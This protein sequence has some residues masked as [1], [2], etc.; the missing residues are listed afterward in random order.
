MD[1]TE[2]LRQAAEKNKSIVCMGLDPVLE[3]IPVKG[4]TE[5]RITKFY[6]DILNAVNSSD[7]KPGI[8]K[9]NY[10]FYAQYGFE[11]LRALKK[12]IEEYKKHFLV[13]LDCKRADIG[14]TSAAYAKEVFDFW[15]ADAI[16]VQPYLGY[17]SIKPFIDYCKKGK[18]V[19]LLVRTSNPGAREVQDL[20]SGNK[21][22]YMKI[23]E[24]VLKYHEPGVSAVVGAT[25]PQELEKISEFFVKS[26][27]SVPF[28]IPGVG[29]Q[30]GSAKEVVSALKKTK[31][32]LAIHRI[33]SSSGINYAYEK[34]NTKDYADAAV[35]AI[36]EL[37]GE[38]GF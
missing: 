32:E 3:K 7:A 24:N 19:Y 18:G 25:Y 20:V 6:L 31:N 29:A 38:I 8:V 28:L 36:E 21:P 4:D 33:N 5:Q 2:R 13:I 15:G 27:K 26:G 14:N 11:G 37:N 10:A 17:D 22:V 12:I 9:P 23:A 30:G 1:F 34:S 35:K 16:T